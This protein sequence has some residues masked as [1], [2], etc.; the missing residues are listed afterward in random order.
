[1]KI[2]CLLLI[3]YYFIFIYSLNGS[4]IFGKSFFTKVWSN[5]TV[6]WKYFYTRYSKTRAIKKKI[7][8]KKR[9]KDHYLHKVCPGTKKNFGRI[10]WNEPWSIFSTSEGMIF[11][12]RTP[13][14]NLIFHPVPMLIKK[15]TKEMLANII[16]TCSIDS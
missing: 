15:N 4:K 10:Y 16:F 11:L 14:I 6:F 13:N 5:N 12:G 2:Y 1:M 7:K 3:S 9:I 8:S